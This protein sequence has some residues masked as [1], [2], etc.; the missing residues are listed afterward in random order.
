MTDLPPLPPPM[1]T[2][3]KMVEDQKLM[4]KQLVPESFQK[5]KIILIASEGEELSREEAEI[6]KEMS[7]GRIYVPGQRPDEIWWTK[8]RRAGGTITMSVK[9][10]FVAL[11]H[12]PAINARLAPGERASIP[13]LGSVKTQARKGHQYLSGI[14]QTI[15]LFREYLLGITAETISLNN[16]IDFEIHVNDFKSIRGITSPLAI[17]D[18]IAFFDQQN[19][20]NPDTEV[21]N[22]IRPSLAS[23]HG[24]LMI[25]SSPYARNGELFLNYQKYYGPEGDPLIIFIKGSTRYFNPSIDQRIIDRAIER[26]PLA[27]RCE[28]GGEF[29]DDCEAFVNREQIESIV[30][31]D[32]TELPFSRDI[33]YTSCCDPSGGAAD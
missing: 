11:S 9:A 8:G 22:A 30:I 32:R 25:T 17:I 21:L 13:L 29:R 5:Q 12:G 31:I 26:D 3:R 28:F 15:E 2:M 18:E 20:A 1:F 14:F 19:S 27:A 4:G 24:Q 6:Y 10:A 23:L 7:G 16:N 33:A